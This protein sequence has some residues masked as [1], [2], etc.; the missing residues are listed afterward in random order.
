M[1][2]VDLASS[3]FREIRRAEER[4]AKT[5]ATLA[6]AIERLEELRRDLPQAE[7]SDR[8]ALAAALVDG[9]SEPVG[10]AEEIRAEI[11]RQ[12]RRVEALRLAAA[13]ARSQIRKLVDEHRD[14]WLRQTRRKLVE[15]QRRYEA[16][17]AELEAA[18]EGLGNEATL[19]SWLD[20]GEISEAANDAL[21]GGRRGDDRPVMAFSRA[22]AELRADAEHLA[23]LVDT[24]RDDREVRIA[25]ERMTT[26]AVAGS[27]WRG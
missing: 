9:K 12:E 2:P 26:G 16:S 1:N 24:P 13:E 8:T 21:G 25:Y 14:S 17:I 5:E 19:A 7:A 15:A 23:G 27:E 11:V 10:K 4:I 6:Q 18:R 3:R 20:R 22:I